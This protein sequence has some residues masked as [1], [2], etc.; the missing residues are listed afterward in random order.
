MDRFDLRVDVPAVSIRDLQTTA[1]GETSAA[2][3]ARIQAART[4]QAQRFKDCDNIRQNADITGQQLEELVTLDSDGQALMKQ[5]AE[6]FNLTAR[7]Y[8]RVLRVA[9]TIADLAQSQTVNSAHLGEAISYR[10]F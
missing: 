10:F 6:R 5:A 2:V 1:R 9:R 4:L 7:G 8:H 3:G